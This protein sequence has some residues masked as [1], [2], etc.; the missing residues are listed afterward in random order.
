LVKLEVELMKIKLGT[1]RLFVVGIVMGLLAAVVQAYTF[2]VQ[3]PEGFGLAFV[4]HPNNLFNWIV[5]NIP[6]VNNWVSFPLH[7]AFLIYPPLT[8]IGVFIGSSIAAARSKE[9]KLRPGPVRNK[10][11]AI[12]LGFLVIN[13]G[14][15]W[16]CDIRTALLVGYGSVLGII[17]LISIAAG[18]ILATIYL[19]SRARKGAM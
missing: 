7:D 17:A 2:D 15:L 8:I 18:V 16:D 13:F 10:F 6:W 9:L 1:Y 19:R 11:T 12:L 5:N 14:L 4:G 3:P